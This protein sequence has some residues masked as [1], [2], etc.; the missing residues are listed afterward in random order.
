M[1][2]EL[3]GQIESIIQDLPQTKAGLV[4]PDHISRWCDKV[5]SRWSVLPSAIRKRQM[6]PVQLASRLGRIGASEIG[7]LAH[8]KEGKDSPFGGDPLREFIL[9]KRLIFPPKDTSPV[10]LRGV[11]LERVVQDL[12]HDGIISENVIGPDTEAINVVRNSILHTPQGLSVRVTPDDIILVRGKSG[13]E[14]RFLLDYKTSVPHVDDGLFDSYKSQVLLGGTI[15]EKEGIRIDGL[16]IVWFNP[17]TMEVTPTRVPWDRDRGKWL[18][19]DVPAWASAQLMSGIIPEIP[20]VPVCPDIPGMSDD[21]KRYVL[22][23]KMS[24]SLAADAEKILEGLE[25]M[26]FPYFPGAKF[27]VPTAG[28]YATVPKPNA[29]SIQKNAER[30]ITSVGI[31]PKYNPA[32]PDTE[33]RV[34]EVFAAM[35]KSADGILDKNVV[36]ALAERTLAAL[37]KTPDIDYLTERLLDKWNEGHPDAKALVAE[38]CSR[39]VVLGRDK[40]SKSVHESLS[41]QVLPTLEIVR[42]HIEVVV[43]S[44][45]ERSASALDEAFGSN[46]PSPKNSDDKKKKTKSLSMG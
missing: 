34:S 42:D 12:V 27:E 22:L 31:E 16:M 35:R 45:L 44:G 17:E 1:S 15:A 2:D 36:D 3:R 7:D 20:P 9:S 43:K 26:D 30:I 5:L 8:A 37:P 14:L 24:E 10:M 13:K 18:A 39:S 23:R 6:S 19:Y 11:L 25:K 41:G 38:L 4:N 21:A 40:G 46:P 28:V 32:T 33:M 29:K